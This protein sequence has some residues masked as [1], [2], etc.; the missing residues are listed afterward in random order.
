[1]GISY[2]VA[3]WLNSIGHDAVHLSEQGLHTLDDHLIVEK[4]E[5]DKRLF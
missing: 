3:Q 1:M 5:K 4:A 2:K